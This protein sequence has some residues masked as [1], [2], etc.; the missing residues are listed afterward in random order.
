MAE[1]N[2]QKICFKLTDK[3]HQ[4]Y[5]EHEMRHNLW[6]QRD[7]AFLQKYSKKELDEIQRF[8]LEFNN[9]MEDKIAEIGGQNDVN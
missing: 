5:E 9:Y 4:V 8:M 3:G 7:N 6:L 1:G 2:N